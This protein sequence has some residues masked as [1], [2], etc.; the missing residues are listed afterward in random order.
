MDKIPLQKK[1]RGRTF[2]KVLDKI[3]E[4]QLQRKAVIHPA[5][6]YS[7]HI[8][9]LFEK[10]CLHKASSDKTSLAMAAAATTKKSS[11]SGTKR[12]AESSKE[13]HVKGAKK[14]KVD[15]E[16]TKLEKKKHSKK[17]DKPEK[18]AKKPKKEE[19]IDADSD[20]VDMD[21]G[22][23]LKEAEVEDTP[24]ENAEDGIHPERRQFAAGQGPNGMCMLAPLVHVSN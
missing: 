15:A 3:V 1:P 11:P 4:K 24:M 17:E 5:F 16:S 14:S 13:V 19:S 2:E 21:G 7:Y 20:D 23:P 18:K 9:F 10:H 22:A 12:K 6:L 8:L